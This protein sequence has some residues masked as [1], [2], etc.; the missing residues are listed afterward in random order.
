MLYRSELKKLLITQKGLLLLTVCLLLK[1]VFLSA[2]PEMKDS[3]IQLSQKQ[4]DKYLVQLHGENT[5]EKSAWI[6][7]EYETCTQTIASRE[8]MEQKRNTGSLSDEQW[9]EYLDAL[10]TSYLHENAA[11][12]FA[13]KAEQFS[14]QP[15]T[16][17]P[18]HYIYEYGW[19]TIFTL[20]QFPDIFLLFGLLLLSAQ[21]FPFEAQ[22]GM[23]PVLLSCKNGRIKILSAKL[24]S[25]LTIATISAILSGGLEVA[26]FFLRGWCNDPNAPL[27]SVKILASCTLPLSLGQS[28]GA[29]L[30][31]RSFAAL[32]FTTF[33]F[34]VSVWL[35]NTQN[36]V[37]LSL[38]LL[39]L[40]L[41]WNDPTALFFPTGLLSG[42][43]FLLWVGQSGFSVLFPVTVALGYTTALFVFA[44][45]RYQKGL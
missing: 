28:Y 31:L 17:P 7:E 44:V 35:K 32:L 45:K 15:D 11:K 24:L 30:I 3:R 43:R 4:Y 22:S 9:D 34:S 29:V 27:Y 18:A 14:V 23:L 6:L 8:E 37:L 33:I 5:A 26:V 21:C 42:T 40:P 36:L 2:V 38:C 10:D 39:A 25:L 20:G 12:I 13:E 16:V 19:Q 1:L 41:L